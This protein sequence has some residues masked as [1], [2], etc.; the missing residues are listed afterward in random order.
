MTAPIGITSRKPAASAEQPLEDIAKV[1]PFLAK[2]LEAVGAEA[3][4]GAA[5]EPSAGPAA[6]SLSMPKPLAT[7]RT[8]S[9]P[10][11]SEIFTAGS[12]GS[13]APGAGARTCR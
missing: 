11:P 1:E 9:R 7:I 6:R 8:A 2:A 4:L 10:T 12:R 13:A 5:P 3:A